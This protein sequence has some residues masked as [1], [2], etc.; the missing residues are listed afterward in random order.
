M[1]RVP[2]GAARCIELIRGITSESSEVRHSWASVAAEWADEGEVDI[3]EAAPIA[4]VLAWVALLETDKFR[5][6]AGF[7]DSLDSLAQK[8]LVPPAVL[9]LVI[10]GLSRQDLDVAEV[11]FYDTLV[12]KL[13][14]RREK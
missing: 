1:A 10:A 3:H 11:E 7:L 9:E 12:A 13:G 6:R 2:I 4:A 14:E 8:D 5:I